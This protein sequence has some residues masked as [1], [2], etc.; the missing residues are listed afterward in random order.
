MIFQSPVKYNGE[1]VR[2]HLI[3][4]VIYINNG[5]KTN[6][7]TNNTNIC[8]YVYVVL[9]IYNII[10]ECLFD[11]LYSLLVLCIFVFVSVCIYKY[12]AYSRQ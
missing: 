1:G 3:I 12:K 4:Y 9:Y 2:F 7:F 11:Y 6:S 8:I 10:Y 5:M